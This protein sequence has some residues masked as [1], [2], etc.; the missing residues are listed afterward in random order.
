MSKR[1]AAPGGRRDP[2]RTR[3]GWHHHVTLATAA[4]RF[5]TLRRRRLISYQVLDTLQDLLRCWTGTCT[6]CGR[7]LTISSTRTRT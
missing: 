4:Q 6:T 1:I 2:D 5:L 3:R 7:P